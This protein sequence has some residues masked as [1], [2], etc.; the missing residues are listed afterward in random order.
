MELESASV[1]GPFLWL[2]IH[3][4]SGPRFPNKEWKPSLDL[5]DATVG[6]LED[7]EASWPEKGRLI[8]DGFV[9]DRLAVGPTDAIAR[10]RWL[11]L[12]PA[13]LGFR[14]QPYEQLIAVFRRM[15]HEDQVAEV[16]IAKQQ[17]LCER[18]DLGWWSEFWSRFLFRTVRY[19]YEPWRAFVWLALL[20]IV[21]TMMFLVARLPSLGMMVPSDKEAY[22]AGEKTEKKRLPYYYPRFNPFVYSLDVIFPF[23][24]GQ[25]SHW[26]LSQQQSRAL[27]Y[28]IFEGYSL[29]Q[30]FVG[31]VLLLVAAAVPAG[32][33][34]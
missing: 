6:P 9:Y 19:G 12:Q 15:G 8:L 25:K 14:P 29:V 16:A 34:K 13:K 26:R 1:K 23:D 27:V 33:I 31:W 5:T 17:D 28:W 32:F 24:L 2:D 30:L 18:G 3:K 11:H 4:Y 10:L 20:V 7:D 21:G 22:E